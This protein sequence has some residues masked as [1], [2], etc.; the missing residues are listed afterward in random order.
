MINKIYKRIHNKY[1]NIFNFFFFLRYLFSIFLIF[2]SLFFFIPKFFDYGKKQETI[3]EYLL[4]YYNLETTNDI[5]IKY[6]IFPLPNLSIKNVNLKINEKPVIL[7]SNNIEIY[8]KFENIYDYKNFKANKIVVNNSEIYLNVNNASELINYVKDLE[9]RIQIKK[10]NL[11]FKK[12]NR[13][14]IQIK[15]INFSNFGYKKYH[16]EAEVFNKKL[17]AKLKNKNRN[18]DVK[19][20]KTGLKATFE[21]SE[22]ESNNTIVGTS[23]I[24]LLNNILKFDFVLNDNKF[25]VSN[26]NFRNKNLSFSLDSEIKFYPYFFSNSIVNINE[27]DSNLINSLSLDKIFK[28]IYL[29]KKIN[30]TI[31]INFKNKSYFTNLVKSYSSEMGLANGRLV[32]SNKIHVKGSEIICIGNSILTE[33]F[34]RLNFNCDINIKNKKK[35]FQNFSISKSID[36]NQ[37]KL[38][39][40]G[41]LN[42][43]KRK[44]NFKKISIEKGYLANKED[45]KYF[46]ENFERVLFKDGFFQIFNK[47]KIKEFFITIS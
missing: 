31:N 27:I 41:T 43:R 12:K 21:L 39:I 1:S 37:I 42:L 33:E 17:R 47:D 13:T 26:S 18:L 23:K 10:L 29:L 14:L 20:L 9:S 32:F 6:K 35:F 3:K 40:K 19:I 11:N 2:T 7:K 24:K 22:K 4:N 16:F 34:P 8:L 36:Q 38:N 44:I 46:K 25:K 30:S 5:Q 28:N 15:N 45:I